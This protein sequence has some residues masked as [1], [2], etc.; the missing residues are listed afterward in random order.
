MGHGSKQDEA[1]DVGSAQHPSSSANEQ[2]PFTNL[3]AQR[4]SLSGLLTG[5]VLDSK[6]ALGIQDSLIRSP[7]QEQFDRN[8]AWLEEGLVSDKRL[9][10]IKEG[11]LY[12]E[13][14][15]LKLSGCAP[16]QLYEK[17]LADAQDFLA[18]QIKKDIPNSND[19]Q[20]LNNLLL[21]CD[22]PSIGTSYRSKLTILSAYLPKTKLGQSFFARYL[23][24]LS[25]FEQQLKSKGADRIF[26]E[27]VFSYLLC[28]ERGKALPLQLS[29]M[30]QEC[31]N[32][33]TSRD[34]KQEKNLTECAAQVLRIMRFAQESGS[35]LSLEFRGK[36]AGLLAN[37]KQEVLDD[38]EL[39]V[40]LEAHQKTLAKAAELEEEKDSLSKI[41]ESVKS[42]VSDRKGSSGII[43]LF[44]GAY[45]WL[46]SRPS[47]TDTLI[48]SFLNELHGLLG[49]SLCSEQ[50]KKT[51]ELKIEEQ[52]VA[53]LLLR[54]RKQERED[55][56]AD[57]GKEKD[58]HREEKTV[59]GTRAN[60][61]DLLIL[62]EF[63]ALGRLQEC[64]EEFSSRLSKAFERVAALNELEQHFRAGEVQILR[65]RAKNNTAE[66][67]NIA[68][69]DY[70]RAQEDKQSERAI[71]IYTANT[72]RRE[73]APYSIYSSLRD[74][75]S[76][77]LKDYGFN[78]SSTLSNPQLPSFAQAKDKWEKQQMTQALAESSKTA[79]KAQEPFEVFCQMSRRQSFF[80]SELVPAE[81][82][83]PKLKQKGLA[84][85]TDISL[86]NA[87]DKADLNIT[88]VGLTSDAALL[89]QGPLREHLLLRLLPQ[90]GD[91]E[92]KTVGAILDVHDFLLRGDD[93]KLHTLRCLFS[94]TFA[95]DKQS[96]KVAVTE[97][98]AQF[99]G[100]KG[101]EH[102]V[103]EEKNGIALKNKQEAAL[104]GGLWLSDFVLEKE[105]GRIRVP[106]GKINENKKEQPAF[107]ERPIYQY[108]DADKEFSPQLQELGQDEVEFVRK[109]EAHA[110]C[111]TL[112]PMDVKDIA[113]AVRPEL[114]NEKGAK[115]NFVPFDIASGK[116]TAEQSFE[117]SASYPFS[118]KE[119]DETKEIRSRVYRLSTQE[120]GIVN[121][122]VLSKE[123][124]E[125][126]A[127][128]ASEG[129]TPILLRSAQPAAVQVHYNAPGKGNRRDPK[130]PYEGYIVAISRWQ[131]SEL[132]PEDFLWAKAAAVPG[133]AETF[134]VEDSGGNRRYLSRDSL[135]EFQ[136]ARSDFEQTLQ[137][138]G[139]QDISQSCQKL[140]QDFLPLQEMLAK[141]LT[142]GKKTENYVDTLKRLSRD[143]SQSWKSSG[144]SER[145]EEL[146]NLREKI[147]AIPRGLQID[148]FEQKLGLLELQLSSI[149][150]LIEDDSITKLA[151]VIGTLKPDT[152]VEW[153]K[154]DGV[155]FA[156]S[157]FV[158]T[159]SGVYL[160]TFGVKGYSAILLN[161]FYTSAGG[162]V[163]GEGGKAFVSLYRAHVASDLQLLL[164]GELSGE[165]MSSRMIS[166]IAWG[167]ANCFA[168]VSAGNIVGTWAKNTTLK[169][170]ESAARVEALGKFGKTIR[171]LGLD[172]T[173]HKTQLIV[174][175]GIVR[176]ADK[177]KK[178][179][180]I[181]PKLM[182]ESRRRFIEMLRE[183]LEEISEESFEGFF[184]ALAANSDKVGNDYAAA[185]LKFV[186]FTYS[187]LT[188][189][190]GPGFDFAGESRCNHV[191]IVRGENQVTLK[192][193]YEGT[194][195]GL[196]R[197]LRRSGYVGL[198]H[199]DVEGVLRVEQQEEVVGE[200]GKRQMLKVV[201][202]FTPTNEKSFMTVM[203]QA[204]QNPDGSSPLRDD[205][206]LV[207][208]A[209]GSYTV[210]HLVTDG[211]RHLQGYLEDQGLLV[212]FNEKTRTLAV[213]EVSSGETVR[214]R[215]GHE[216]APPEVDES[217]HVLCGDDLEQ[218]GWRTLSKVQ[219][220]RREPLNDWGKFL[221][222]QG[223]QVI[224]VP[225]E[226]FQ[227]KVGDELLWIEAGTK[228]EPVIRNRDG[229]V[230]EESKLS[231]EAKD[232]LEE[233][234]Q[235]AVQEK[236]P[237]YWRCYLAG[238]PQVQ[239]DLQEEGTD[240]SIKVK[241]AD[242][243]YIVTQDAQQGLVLKGSNGAVLDL[244]KLEGEPRNVFNELL[245]Y[246][247]TER[248]FEHWAQFLN[249]PAVEVSERPLRVAF[250]KNVVFIEQGADGVPLIKDEAGNVLEERDFYA[251]TKDAL[252]KLVEK[253][254]NNVEHKEKFERL[255][256]PLHRQIQR[257][258]TL[259]K[260]KYEEIR[261]PATN[262]LLGFRI[263]P[264]ASGGVLGK[265]AA[266]KA[267]RGVKLICSPRKNF[268]VQAGAMFDQKQN[269]HYLSI[270]S[271]AK[272]QEVTDTKHEDVHE[273]VSRKPQC[274]ASGEVFSA[275]PT[276]PMWAKK[277]G[278]YER[279]C[280]VDE[281]LAYAASI[282]SELEELKQKG[283]AGEGD[284]E[285]IKR[286]LKSFGKS[287][288]K[289]LKELTFQNRPLLVALTR[290]DSELL[291]VLTEGKPELR[292]E[293]EQ[294]EKKVKVR[295]PEEH[296]A[297][298]AALRKA[299]VG[300]GTDE[301]AEHICN[302]AG[303]AERLQGIAQNT[304]QLCRDAMTPGL[305]RLELR[306]RQGINEL[307]KTE[308]VVFAQVQLG[309]AVFR[310]D[311]APARKLAEPSFFD[312]RLRLVVNRT[313]ALELYLEKLQALNDV[314][315]ELS[316]RSAVLILREEGAN[317]VASSQAELE[318]FSKAVKEL[319]DCAE[320]G[321]NWQGEKAKARD[322][323]LAQ[324]PWLQ[325]ILEPVSLYPQVRS[326]DANGSAPNP[327][328]DNGEQKP[329]EEARTSEPEIAKEAPAVKDLKPEL[330][331]QLPEDKR[332]KKALARVKEHPHPA[333]ELAPAPDWT[334][335][336][337]EARRKWFE[338][339]RKQ[340][341][342]PEIFR[343]RVAYVGGDGVEYQETLVDGKTSFNATTCRDQLISQL[344]IKPDGTISFGKSGL[345]DGSWVA[346]E[347]A[348]EADL[349]NLYTCHGI[350]LYDRERKKLIAAHFRD[351][352][353]SEFDDDG[354]RDE[355]LEYARFFF[356]D[357]SQVE[358]HVSGICGNSSGI[359][360]TVPNYN[361][362][363]SKKS[364][365][366][367][368]QDIGLQE[369]NK[370]EHWGD[371]K[372]RQ[373]SRLSVGDK[374]S[375]W[376][377][378]GE[379]AQW[380]PTAEPANAPTSVRRTAEKELPTLQKDY[381]K[382]LQT[383]QAQ[384]DELKAR[385]PKEWREHI[386]P[387][388]K[389]RLESAKKVL[390]AAGLD[391]TLIPCRIENIEFEAIKIT[392]AK[393]KQGLNEY[394]AALHEML[395]SDLV[396]SPMHL[397]CGQL[398]GGYDFKTQTIF[399]SDDAIERLS[400]TS[401]EYHEEVHASF[402][403]HRRQGTQKTLTLY[404][405]L[406]TSSPGSQN[407]PNSASAHD[408]ELGLD[409]IASWTEG[410]SHSLTVLEASSDPADHSSTF[411]PD[412]M[413][414]DLKAELDCAKRLLEFIQNELDPV[415]QA[416]DTEEAFRTAREPRRPLGV[417]QVRTLPSG[418]GKAQ[419][420]LGSSGEARDIVQVYLQ[421]KTQE[422]SMDVES[423][424][425][426]H[427]E[428]MQEG[429][430][431]TQVTTPAIYTSKFRKNADT[432]KHMLNELIPAL[433]KAQRYQ[434]KHPH[435]HNK[436]ER[437][438]KFSEK[439]AQIRNIVAK[440][441]PCG[442][443][444]S[445]TPA[446]DS[447]MRRG[448]EAGARSPT[449]ETVRRTAEPEQPKTV[450]GARPDAAPLSVSPS[451]FDVEAERLKRGGRPE[452]QPAGETSASVRR[453]DEESFLHTAARNHLRIK[454]ADYQISTDLD[455]KKLFAERKFEL[456]PYLRDKYEIVC[457]KGM[458]KSGLKC[459]DSRDGPKGMTWEIVVRDKQAGSKEVGLCVFEE[460]SP[461]KLKVLGFEVE[462]LSEKEDLA[463]ALARCMNIV[464]GNKVE[465]L[466]AE[467][468]GKEY[469]GYR[470]GSTA[471]P[472]PGAEFLNNA[473]R[474]PKLYCVK[475]TL[476]GTMLAELLF[477]PERVRKIEG[478][479]QQGETG[480]NIDF[481]RTEVPLD[482]IADVS[483][484]RDCCTSR[485]LSDQE[486][487]ELDQKK[488]D[489][490]A[491]AFWE[492]YYEMFW[493]KKPL[494]NDDGYPAFSPDLY[495]RDR[496]ITP[497]LIQ[498]LR[499]D[500]ARILVVGSGTGSLEKVLVDLCGVDP[501]WICSTSRKKDRRM[502]LPRQ[503]QHCLWDY[504]DE[505]P[506]L[507]GNQ[508]FDVL[509]T[510]GALFVK[511]PDF[512]V[513]LSL[514]IIN[515]Y[516]WTD[517]FQLILRNLLSLVKD[518]GELRLGYVPYNG[519]GY[520]EFK[521]FCEKFQPPIQVHTEGR[522][523]VVRRKT[524]AAQVPVVTLGP[525]TTSPDERSPS[526]FTPRRTDEAAPTLKR[527]AEPDNSDNK[528]RA[529]TESIP[530]L[531]FSSNISL[532]SRDAVQ[533]KYITEAEQ[534]YRK[535]FP[536]SYGVPSW[537][538]QYLLH[539]AELLQRSTQRKEQYIRET[540]TRML[541][542]L[543]SIS[544]DKQQHVLY[545]LARINVFLNQVFP[546]LPTPLADTE[547]M[548][549]CFTNLLCQVHSQQ[550]TNLFCTRLEADRQKLKDPGNF[551][552]LLYYAMDNSSGHSMCFVN[553]RYH[554][555]IDIEGQKAA[556]TVAA[557]NK[558]LG[559]QSVYQEVL[560]FLSQDK[561]SLFGTTWA[562]SGIS[563]LGENLECEVY[564]EV[565][566]AND[567]FILK[568]QGEHG[569]QRR[570]ILKKSQDSSRTNNLICHEFETCFG[571]PTYD[572]STLNSKTISRDDLFVVE[573]RPSARFDLAAVKK[574]LAT[575]MTKVDREKVM[576][577][578][579]MCFAQDYILNVRDGASSTAL[580]GTNY[581]IDLMSSEV[582]R[583]DKDYGNDSNRQVA[584][585]SHDKQEWIAL[586]KENLKHDPQ[587]EKLFGKLSEGFFDVLHRVRKD[588]LPQ[589]YGA[590]IEGKP[591]DLFRRLE[592]VYREC[593]DA[594]PES[595]TAPAQLLFG[596]LKADI[597][598]RIQKSDSEI[599]ETLGL[600]APQVKRSDEQLVLPKVNV[601]KDAL[602]MQQTEQ[603]KH[604]TSPAAVPRDTWA[605][606][607]SQ[608]M[609]IGNE[610]RELA[611]ALTGKAS[612]DEKETR[613]RE[614]KSKLPDV[615]AA[616]L[617]KL[618]L[619]SNLNLPG[620]VFTVDG[621]L[622][623]KLQ[624]LDGFEQDA[625]VTK[626]KEPG[627]P[628]L[629]VLIIAN[630]SARQA[631][632]RQK[633][634]QQL[635]ARF[636]AQEFQ[637]D[638]EVI[639][640]KQMINKSLAQ[641]K[642]RCDA[643]MRR[644]SPS[645]EKSLYS[646]LFFSSQM[647]VAHDVLVELKLGGQSVGVASLSVIGNEAELGAVYIEPAFRDCGFGKELYR[648]VL[649]YCDENGISSLT[650]D[651]LTDP[652]LMISDTVYYEFGEYRVG[653][654]QNLAEAEGPRQS[655]LTRLSALEVQAVKQSE[656]FTKDLQKAEQYRR[657][658]H[659]LYKY[660]RLSSTQCQRLEKSKRVVI[661]FGSGS[662][663]AINAIAQDE[664]VFAV[665]I[666][667]RLSP[668]SLSQADDEA[669]TIL[670]SGKA[671]AQ[672]RPTYLG[673]LPS[674]LAKSNSAVLCRS[675]Q[676]V[677]D[678]ELLERADQI[679]ASFPPQSYIASLSGARMLF[680]SA[681]KLMK[682]GAEAVF[683]TE[684][685]LDN[686]IS[687]KTVEDNLKEA[688]ETLGDEIE[689]IRIERV[690]INRRDVH[691]ALKQSDYYSQFSNPHNYEMFLNSLSAEG[692][693]QF[694]LLSGLD[695]SAPLELTKIVLRKRSLAGQG[696]GVHPKQK[697]VSAQVISTAP[698]IRR[699][700]EAAPTQIL[701]RVCQSSGR[702]RQLALAALKKLGVQAQD[703]LP[704][705]IQA[706]AQGKLTLLE[707]Q[708]FLLHIIPAK[709]EQLP[710]IFNIMSEHRQSSQ[711][712]LLCLQCI[713]AGSPLD[714]Q[715]VR[716]Y[717]DLIRNGKA[718]EASISA[719]LLPRLNEAITA[720]NILSFFQPLVIASWQKQAEIHNILSFYLSW[721]AAQGRSNLD[722]YTQLYPALLNFLHVP[723]FPAIRTEIKD[724][725]KSCNP[726]GHNFNAN[727]LH[728]LEQMLDPDNPP[729]VL[730]ETLRLIGTGNLNPDK[731]LD[732]AAKIKNGHERPNKESEEQRHEKAELLTSAVLSLGERAW[733]VLSKAVV[734]A[735]ARTTLVAIETLEKMSELPPTI[736][737]A[738]CAALEK[739]REIERIDT[740]LRTMLQGPQ[741]NE[742]AEAVVSALEN[743]GGSTNIGLVEAIAAYT[744]SF[745]SRRE[746]VIA[747]LEPLL[748]SEN[749]L[750]QV[751][752]AAALWFFNAEHQRAREVL[753]S[754][755]MAAPSLDSPEVEKAYLR[756]ITFIEQ[757]K[758]ILPELI[759]AKARE[760]V[761]DP[762]R[763]DSRSLAVLAH[764]PGVSAE[765][766]NA[767]VAFFAQLSRA[768]QEK[769]TERLDIFEI[770]NL[771]HASRVA[772]RMGAQGRRLLP[773][774][775]R[776]SSIPDSG[777]KDITSP[778]SDMSARIRNDARMAAIEI[779]A[780]L[781]VR[782]ERL[783][784]SELEALGL[785][786]IDIVLAR[787]PATNR[788][789]IN[790]ITGAEILLHLNQNSRNALRMLSH[791]LAEVHNLGAGTS[792]DT[793]SCPARAA[794]A[795]G[796]VPE[797]LLASQ[798]SQLHPRVHNELQFHLS[799]IA[800]RQVVPEQVREAAT[801]ALKAL[802]Q[803]ATE[804]DED[805]GESGLRRTAEP[806]KPKTDVQ[807]DFSKNI[808]SLSPD[809]IDA[810]YI[811]EARKLFA[812]AFPKP[813]VVPSWA[814]QYL[815]HIAQLLQRS[816]QRNEPFI[817]DT[818]TCMLSALGS[819]SKDQQQHVIYH[820][821]RVNVF[822]NTVFSTLPPS[823][824]NT[825]VM[826][827]CFDNLLCRVHSQPITDYF[828][829]HLEAASKQLKDPKRLAVLLYYALE[830]GSQHEMLFRT[831]TYQGGMGLQE[832]Q[833]ANGISEM[834]KRL[835]AQSVYKSV[836]E[837]LSQ[838]KVQLFNNEWAIQDISVLGDS[839]ESKAYNEISGHQSLFVLSLQGAKGE[840]L[841]VI[842]KK[843]RASSRTNNLVCREF[844]TC[845]GLPSYAVSGLSGEGATRDDLFLVEQ[846]PSVQFDLP[847]VKKLL[848]EDSTKVDREKV[849]RTLGMCFA[850]NYILNV[851]DGG[852]R[853]PLGNVNYRIDLHNSEVF[854]IDKD[855]GSDFPQG[856]ID[857]V[858]E[859]TK[860]WIKGLERIL[861]GDAQRQE[862]L[863]ELSIGFFS[864]L[865]KVRQDVRPGK[866]GKPEENA[867]RTFFKRLEHL[868]R[869][870]ETAAPD[871]VTAPTQ[872][873]FS[874]LKAEVCE[875][876]GP[877][878]SDSQI[879]KSLGLQPHR[880]KRSDEKLVLPKLNTETAGMET[881]QAQKL[882]A[883]LTCINSSR[884]KDEKE[885]YRQAL[886]ELA[887]LGR[888]QSSLHQDVTL[889]LIAELGAGNETD[890]VVG[891]ITSLKPGRWACEH[892]G[893]LA[894]DSQLDEAKRQAA[895]RLLEQLTRG[896]T[897]SETVQAEGQLKPSPHIKRTSEK[898]F[899]EI[900][901][902]G[903]PI[904][905]PSVDASQV[906]QVYLD[907]AEKLI[908]KLKQPVHV[909]PRVTAA[910]TCHLAQLMQP[911]ELHS[912]RFTLSSLNQALVSLSGEAVSHETQ[913]TG[914][915]YYARLNQLLAHIKKQG[916]GG[917]AAIA[918]MVKGR[919]FQ[920]LCSAPIEP[921]IAEF[922]FGLVAKDAAGCSANAQV[923]YMRFLIERLPRSY[924]S[925]AVIFADSNSAGGKPVE[926]IASLTQ[927]LN[928][929]LGAGSLHAQLQSVVVG[930]KI[931][932]PDPLGG[933]VTEGQV[934]KIESTRE[935]EETRHHSE[936]QGHNPSLLVTVM[937]NSGTSKVLLK[938]V[939]ECVRG[940]SEVVADF[941]REL[942]SKDVRIPQSESAEY[943][944]TK[945]G[946]FCLQVVRICPNAGKLDFGKVL[947]EVGETSTVESH[948][949]VA[950]FLRSLGGTL[951]LELS[952]GI[953]DGGLR[954][955][956]L[957]HTNKL[958]LRID[959]E[960][961]CCPMLQTVRESSQIL[962]GL[963]KALDSRIPPDRHRQ[964]YWNEV[965]KGFIQTRQAL[966]EEFKKNENQNKFVAILRSRLGDRWED[967]FSY[968]DHS[969][970]EDDQ[971]VIRQILPK[972]SL[973]N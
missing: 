20:E 875:R 797:G 159:M 241:I 696:M 28:L 290:G 439:I 34:F 240:K 266:Q 802:N 626:L 869:D 251:N 116:R 194:K 193:S 738:L 434:N 825:E 429:L 936:P 924:Y 118:S 518:N 217:K 185:M 360:S 851:T 92:R 455:T 249:R 84:F 920:I 740:L 218:Q 391:Y 211:G 120:Q 87:G 445:L 10:L 515:H 70:A 466:S 236:N 646:E 242:Q 492:R 353:N 387:L 832:R 894:S 506:E 927:T 301:R 55:E 380:H 246:A 593:K 729:L 235:R 230:L 633:F 629:D 134:L 4:T 931:L 463:R 866:D 167:T 51:L 154:T 817:R 117:R 581:R 697:A 628:D 947:A 658:H 146:K 264:D 660:R 852:P 575:D 186:S 796:S 713:P 884:A 128:K 836:L 893:K 104:R 712:V 844:E 607:Q 145:L 522:T 209:D 157:I 861:Q 605:Y 794:L 338:E 339:K 37:V 596:Q 48:D 563:V 737:P 719:R 695:E 248:D 198:I 207:R 65:I 297:E 671:Y 598:K 216:N 425:V 524:N 329:A 906:A 253:S 765:T 613:L 588:V 314:C 584:G 905:V 532:L 309:N 762:T 161:S 724:C 57:E 93:G 325:E 619:Q 603:G 620:L 295:T 514:A 162:Y 788:S 144:L 103:L 874:Q 547:V 367:K 475:D 59:A 471:A 384:L 137:H 388:A 312:G 942:S 637:V 917:E 568:L 727:V 968:I 808:T 756:A 278:G 790:S 32:T 114:R 688:A 78:T 42:R 669:R 450:S 231:K 777:V 511:G 126:Y 666:E 922:L 322:E 283:E 910:L 903:L 631:E 943:P 902:A 69:T 668:E 39:R 859:E 40:L 294:E 499:E 604:G 876:I 12:G 262:R 406:V 559:S 175:R 437:R 625:C 337:D 365:L 693:E 346:L 721:A 222:R 683:F 665:G 226:S 73:S 829:T 653:V 785:T 814:E 94:I 959:C 655:E 129:W 427:V 408:A 879:A 940:K 606:G 504:N 750:H 171:Q 21:S 148:E 908:G 842:L 11:R 915:L 204:S 255:L 415:F 351:F 846:R 930:K 33:L 115:Y 105:V 907:E 923:D 618:K 792:L 330:D 139:R 327:E 286:T 89:L 189:A 313:L 882:S 558:Q 635:R 835:G 206:G 150:G 153:L 826:K 22:Q 819:I 243:A 370:H 645:A 245:H 694:L 326:R 885:L 319:V 957:D 863:D 187:T 843:S 213:T 484:Q 172:R 124:Q 95:D 349:G 156:A 971:A 574:L 182:P 359:L 643:R 827:E 281:L 530:Q 789:R 883:L 107:A 774:L 474:D 799:E 181:L 578:L 770:T 422:F 766:V 1:V 773:Q 197:D 855:Y 953:G 259:N 79:A 332:G 131:E 340:I 299:L 404:G 562:I 576:Y 622:P 214:I 411:S 177:L 176:A 254:K 15:S 871:S 577:T 446:F 787:A 136:T 551:A 552:V 891:L 845:F 841:R 548:E 731:L 911:P 287:N 208:R 317:K 783:E 772:G 642:E 791:F 614:L 703:V 748:S 101:E 41:L 293:L 627:Q 644:L 503:A 621:D 112:T 174:A 491:Y 498:K 457:C 280:S 767:D 130:L 247:R 219:N 795:L 864:V 311:I 173:A 786:R 533:T 687:G 800:K 414:S 270:E 538:E 386:L 806:E 250:R 741:A 950:A 413:Q 86:P 909:D 25:D 371:N 397:L 526:S 260:V 71:Q 56:R 111:F 754:C 680:S 18:E 50:E 169:H 75:V 592:K 822:L 685:K 464:S 708:G 381:H 945:D 857:G 432:L 296:Q 263:L 944:V 706:V 823:L 494:Q 282:K 528:L 736:T 418:V 479:A 709:P 963:K 383:T 436:P 225:A 587:R 632:C 431:N 529:A 880:L 556:E 775:C 525:S 31:I 132:K 276:A 227:V 961:L 190:K 123:A 872:E 275:D 853:N 348:C 567:L 454:E 830:Y 739:G 591:G 465:K 925:S 867:P 407:Q 19:Q 877:K 941:A 780:T 183:G 764:L 343:S 602:G 848:T 711:I 716:V 763:V 364:L 395:G 2:N 147:H 537:A 768:L 347:G 419:A 29:E 672:Y 811:S 401:W 54:V 304:Q 865:N 583:I 901:A 361:C 650:V 534:L 828:C 928:D 375:I 221:K 49:K 913:L 323:Q 521:Q 496:M 933:P 438:R 921:E 100:C 269:I 746:R 345:V 743:G 9:H 341:K 516:N 202:E 98:V 854:R 292:K 163:G 315:Q 149:I 234:R 675:F 398:G 430:I 472:A 847:A 972:S 180:E 566:G 138:I 102:F 36:L 810:Q 229:K 291:K 929:S 459:A 508:K 700:D 363:S 166:Q 887:K 904:A 758:I 453:T 170:V 639:T 652:M 273:R 897:Q 898:V 612:A 109:Q 718:S 850:Q 122:V 356:E 657:A 35:E 99:L 298:E 969:L 732:L 7:R 881:A 747:G 805:S 594:V 376:E 914:L 108:L 67:V 838:E 958:P 480:I 679:L 590:P 47:S 715:E 760:F 868:Y 469:E 81:K 274:L 804:Q 160:P 140:L 798:L 649:K 486:V 300:K 781:R 344:A 597:G 493:H 366:A 482:D 561:V 912:D 821:A 824:A 582:F 565:S 553:D 258:L 60:K 730:R 485:W 284:P 113:Q 535:A 331:V 964:S 444:E 745:V 467:L 374:Q 382:V 82:F 916:A 667:T 726:L 725:L 38:E 779:A 519:E 220:W 357:I 579:G 793:N 420:E 184:D 900:R 224:G 520:Q 541:S 324:E 834:N 478:Q 654:V 342:L 723:S 201:R 252:T 285:E 310:L 106:V 818:V 812:L 460:Q 16:K 543:G 705:I 405:T 662:F 895:N 509:I 394:A 142:E 199:E 714:S 110:Q 513:P 722:T 890:I 400:P 954:N 362:E 151:K 257:V 233:L 570:A 164:R 168:I 58:K 892:L 630:K 200:D 165:E 435:W 966:R 239:A 531:D 335:M 572:V 212:K 702:E 62:R 896:F 512:E 302:I 608:A 334:N 833:I 820:L 303:Y 449:I 279:H 13:Q 256:E 52:K 3:F 500:H 782:G 192:L 641:W 686:R 223:A 158:A 377:E 564:D 742:A 72:L 752:A 510:P 27:E 571:L 946:R 392:G 549:K 489:E 321:E 816:T 935:A 801:R 77:L 306:E 755:A 681:F 536:E 26:A 421:G 973:P 272:L 837:L 76:G 580:S 609:R 63:L 393:N 424:A 560:D 698:N 277:R 74:S 461:T 45:R 610:F 873:L 733:V 809:A 452:T 860:E 443:E 831:R 410:L 96:E 462:E 656:S 195:Q 271:L 523:V 456:A 661:E 433:E 735:D 638:T 188:C 5:L 776:L 771:I 611:T 949:M 710:E 701:A 97:E 663:G 390:D 307:G 624:Q 938:V 191:G 368:L 17:A 599:S 497:T 704:Q 205:F 68:S 308:T 886:Q 918:H 554:G 328:Q 858:S 354:S 369:K 261:D 178:C 426:K 46:L 728:S 720:Q 849:M 125:L 784:D 585:V 967:V 952:L 502:L 203:R 878:N 403:Y 66:A 960:Y 316:E 507:L 550:V 237:F 616:I 813:D 372:I 807:I 555:G 215:E 350:V 888:E 648:D 336:S 734:S 423:R 965:W 396:Y 428:G 517:E 769:T 440:H 634:E 684:I 815:P 948:P 840:S 318:E 61:A 778:Q 265:M 152:V 352:N 333:Q 14:D 267:E 544:K 757:Q 127:N 761:R 451:P 232:L 379:D 441:Y 670:G 937:T 83:N 692:K 939:E 91:I 951:A 399:A 540:V 889:N 595:V 501:G 659:E 751:A 416:E 468:R 43:S 358:W 527:S 8:W 447:V 600:L 636:A 442:L 470:E 490:L 539:I 320:A 289:L 196:Q 473:K 6:L 899:P 617:A 88:Q 753:Y 962:Q 862:L 970:Q 749:P 210:D 856:G 919:E 373:R 448:G 557:L 678:P 647:E 839:P 44:V 155:V 119:V 932:V 23:D 389:Q 870:C 238:R 481:V 569:Q 477:Q 30:V 135:K 121:C 682:P 476:L 677:Q 546:V 803:L 759:A 412:Q 640:D 542:A 90:S 80:T 228:Q 179:N 495:F 305:G 699:T 53:I 505:P 545:H 288:P 417:R 673:C 623:E 385:K 926:R 355:M 690:P 651:M 244:A 691:S 24:A 689:E 674:F 133:A 664:Q 586:L 378:L 141:G 402:D 85:V 934:L 409:E 573:E 956:L 601:D 717:G 268:K 458:P 589:K 488:L 744:Q 676:T 615:P 955:T 707:A 487:K 143:L 483:R 64:H